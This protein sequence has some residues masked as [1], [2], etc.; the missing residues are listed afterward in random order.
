MYNTDRS[1]PQL[2]KCYVV[3][4]ENKAVPCGERIFNYYRVNLLRLPFPLLPLESKEQVHRTFPKCNEI[5]KQIINSLQEQYDKFPNCCEWH[6]KLKRLPFFNRNDFKD[7]HI[8]CADSIVYCYSLI[9]SRKNEDNWCYTIKE[10]LRLAVFRFGC[11]P[12]GYGCALFLE[13]FNKL[14]RRLIACSDIGE[15]VK[16]YVNKILD[17]LIYPS[18]KNDPIEELLHIYNNWLDSF[19]FDFP[20]FQPL[21]RS[22]LTQ[23]SIMTVMVKEGVLQECTYNR[24][25]T[26]KELVEWLNGKSIELLNKM[27]KTK[28]IISA[29]MIVYESS[30]ERKLLDI[31]EAKLLNRYVEEENVYLETLTKWLDIQKRRIAVMRR[32]LPQIDGVEASTSYEEALRRILRFRLW[33]ESQNGCD[34]LKKIDN[35]KE[36]DLQ[37]L[38]KSVCTMS[39]SI[40]RFDREI[41]NGR[42]SADYLVSRGRLDST[43]VEFKFASNTNIE[44]N[45][46][47]QDKIYM[48]ACETDKSIKVIFCFSHD[49][50]IKMKRLCK[51]ICLSE[52]KDYVLIECRKKPSASIVKCDSD[53]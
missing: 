7:S 47:Y 3:S 28:G 20:D 42:G 53:I 36:K 37:T 4:Q 25:V 41:G 30:I 18:D 1:F 24:L 10:Y 9:L 44:S 48:R 35:L 2:F 51:K 46:K 31:E 12:E 45:L 52:D 39:D 33:I 14:L 23:S 22:F 6:R 11:M 34:F 17:E 19:P 16:C 26:N 32:S 27:R 40:Y 49:E 50:V 15:N 8:Q 38:F 21:K 29:M 43:L 5:R 13:T